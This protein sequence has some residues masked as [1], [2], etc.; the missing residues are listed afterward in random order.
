MVFF[1]DF[2][3]ICPYDAVSRYIGS[4]N[5]NLDSIEWGFKSN[6][7]LTILDSFESEIFNFDLPHVFTLSDTGSATPIAYPTWI[8]ISSD[9]P[10]LTKFLDICLAAYAALLSTLLGSFPLKAPPPCAPLPP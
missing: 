6:I 2:L 7:S 8:K 9:T 3:P 1:S 4:L 5:L 10:A